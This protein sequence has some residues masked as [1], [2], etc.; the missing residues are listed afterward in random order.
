M[1]DAKLRIR[2]AKRG[3]E[4]SI[5]LSNLGLSEIPTEILQLSALETVDVSGN[6]LSSLERLGQLP[7][8]RDIIA[9]NN[10]IGTLHE[11]LLDLYFLDSINLVGNPIVN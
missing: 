2:H 6:R 4:K 3:N 5:D 7:H 11:E 8:L 9:Q 10:N 1:S